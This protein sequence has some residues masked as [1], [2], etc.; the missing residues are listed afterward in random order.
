MSH[1]SNEFKEALI[2]KSLLPGAPSLRSLALSH[3]IAFTTVYGWKQKY[4]K[5]SSM[6]KSNRTPEQKLK[7]IIEASSLEGEA[8]GEFLRKEGSQT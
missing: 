7:I 1:Y 6:K 5:I 2:K 8:L 4:A 3:G